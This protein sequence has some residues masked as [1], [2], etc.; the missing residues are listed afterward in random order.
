M[1]CLFDPLIAG[2]QWE[3]AMQPNLW[4]QDSFL[5]SKQQ[6]IPWPITSHDRHEKRKNTQNLHITFL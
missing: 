6:D 1:N 3:V 4:R 2:V 5:A